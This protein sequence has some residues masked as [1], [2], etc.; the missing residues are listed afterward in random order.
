MSQPRRNEA[1]PCGS[2]KR[3]KHCCGREEARAAAEPVELEQGAAERALQAFNEGRYERA[4]KL[5]QGVLQDEPA[6]ADALHVL[7]VIANRRG[8]G[9]RGQE[10]I[11]RAIDIDSGKSVYFLNLGTAF[12][13]QGKLERA[14]AS[15]RKRWPCGRILPRLARTSPLPSTSKADIET[16]WPNWSSPSNSGRILPKRITTWR[17]PCRFWRE[18]RKR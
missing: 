10:L 17:I 5:Y 9:V 6:N 13:E 15:Y 8:D 18:P 3:F 11:E 4:E 7:G 16:R 1:C 12:L 2:G 14:E